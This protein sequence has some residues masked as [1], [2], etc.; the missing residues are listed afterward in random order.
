MRELFTDRRMLLY[1]TGQLFTMLGDTMLF[2]AM[3]IWVK[4]L[5]GSSAAAGLTVF[6]I[7]APAPLAPLVGLL[8]DRVRR[9]RLLSVINLVLAVAVLPLLLVH[10]ARHVWVVYSVM[11]AYGTGRL[12]VSSGQAALLPALVPEHLL[13]HANSALSLIGNGLRLIAPL[14]G[15]D[16]SPSRARTPLS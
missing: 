15:P 5:T 14:P 9:R 16:C 10:D 6:F 8:V 1:L 3:G 4:T 12:V 13:G 7:V 11:A 2:L